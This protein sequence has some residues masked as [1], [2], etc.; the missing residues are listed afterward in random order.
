MRED[1]S[2]H[3]GKGEIITISLYMQRWVALGIIS[4]DYL[5][6]EEDTMNDII[7]LA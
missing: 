5:A 1:A 6:K 2:A 3:K 7:D 4:D